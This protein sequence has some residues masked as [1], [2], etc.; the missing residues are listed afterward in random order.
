[1]VRILV[2]GDRSLRPDRHQDYMDYRGVAVEAE[3]KPLSKGVVSLGR[4]LHPSG[5][6]GRELF[7]SANI[8]LSHT[9][10]IGRTGRG[11]TEGTVI[12]WSI[13]LLRHGYSVVVVDVVGNLHNRLSQAARQLGYRVWYWNS[14]D[15]TRSDSWNW[16]NELQVTNDDD[17]ERCIQ[18]LMGKRNPS[19]SYKY[20]YERDVRWLRALIPIVKLVHTY[21]SKPHHLCQLLA[22]QELLRDQFR[23]YPAVR[24][25]AS[26]VSDLL[27]SPLHEYSMY[28]SGLLNKLEIFKQQSVV[29][30]TE[31]ND[32]ILS[33]IDTRPTLLI[34]RMELNSAK[35]AQLTSLMLNSLFGHVLRR[36]SLGGNRVPLYFM[37][38]EAPQ[39]QDQIDY[40][41]ILAVARN[42][43]VGICLAAQDISQFGEDKQTANILSNCNTIIASKGV[44][45]EVAEYLS[46]QMGSRHDNE[47]TVAR[48]RT[49]YDD[50]KSID[51]GESLLNV[52]LSNLMGPDT[53][54]RSVELPT[55][56]NREIM[57]PPVGNYPAVVLST[58]ILNK[59]FLVEL[60]TAL[61]TI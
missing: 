43:N 40:A 53:S 25:Y 58:P 22:D 38:D 37:L 31:R 42:A 6:C 39:L 44:T 51:Q 12:P 9:A 57:H 8:L 35:S 33:D 7:M 15:P 19:D 14:D 60:N 50:L 23:Q 4:Y 34:I 18:S 20:F 27:Q 47:V 48:Q 5:R 29:S 24:S 54:V 2:P 21:N 17:I 32:F 11:K 26:A 61:R 16:L 55:L 36:Q 46:R 1:M 41:G 30:V 10:V 13:N 28:V 56:G 52:V 3:V 59:P 49:L 45:P